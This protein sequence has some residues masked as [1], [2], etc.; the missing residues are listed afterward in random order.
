[1]AHKQVLAFKQ[2]QIS[3]MNIFSKSTLCPCELTVRKFVNMLHFNKKFEK[4]KKERFYFEYH[5]RSKISIHLSIKRII[6]SS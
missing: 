1:M 4:T 2:N 5:Q 6:Q 3:C